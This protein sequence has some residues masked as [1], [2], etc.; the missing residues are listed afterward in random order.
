MSI[1]GMES[2][3]LHNIT[4]QENVD[5]TAIGNG[6]INSNKDGIPGTLVHVQD[7]SIFIYTC[8]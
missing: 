1:D 2:E 6:A 3:V 4:I 7:Y 8:M 5:V